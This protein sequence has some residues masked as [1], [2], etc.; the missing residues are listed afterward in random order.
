MKMI[1]TGLTDME[2]H[3]ILQRVDAD[4]DGTVSYAEF[5]FKFRDD[6]IFD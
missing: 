5:A 1:S 2:I 3:K 6:P 4:G